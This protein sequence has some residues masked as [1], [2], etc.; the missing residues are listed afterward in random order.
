MYELVKSLHI[1]SAFTLVAA[2]SALAIYVRNGGTKSDHSSGVL[3]RAAHGL[4]LLL[5]ILTGFAILGI[6]KLGVPVWAW[7]K[8]AIWLSLGGSTALL[9][10]KSGTATA[11]W[12]GTILLA[13][14]AAF[15]AIA[16][17]F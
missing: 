4:G 6:M 5:T 15:L 10:R 14:L 16:K 11:I 17:P 8:L 1:L 7:V 9:Y 3:M 12:L 2:L 13:S